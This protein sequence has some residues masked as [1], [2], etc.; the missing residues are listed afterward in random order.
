MATAQ[1]VKR[2][3]EDRL[4]DTAEIFLTVPVPAREA[5]EPGVGSGQP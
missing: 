3:L 1:L 2:R 5:G 4:G